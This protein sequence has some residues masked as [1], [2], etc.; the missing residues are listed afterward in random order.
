M[1]VPVTF[2]VRVQDDGPVANDPPVRDRVVAPATGV[3]VPPQVLVVP[4]TGLA[5]VKPGAV[6][7]KSSVKLT[8]VT[9]GSPTPLLMVIVINVF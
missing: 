9:A 2:T 8:P 7:V 5:T 4:L 6:V 3:N 1:R